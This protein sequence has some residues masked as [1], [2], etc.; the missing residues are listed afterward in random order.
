VTTVTFH[1][2]MWESAAEIWDAI[3]AHPFVR[4]LMDG[5]LTESQLRFYF[6]Q[7]IQYVDVMRRCRWIAAGKA[8]DEEALE[9]LTTSPE[10]SEEGLPRQARL[11]RGFGGDP[12]NLPERA[13]GCRGYTQHMLLNAT[14]GSAVDFL[15]AAGSCPWTYDRIGYDLVDRVGPNPDPGSTPGTQARA[16]WTVRY[17]SDWHHERTDAMLRLIDQLAA[18]CTDSHRRRLI[19]N[20]R[21]GM[22]YEWLFWD[23]A[24]HERGWPV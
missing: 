11:L 7:N 8:E 13:V 14:A 23:D 12:D 16:E 10:L 21:T 9:F 3:H 15:T 22:R 2:V 6:G 5:T 20:F 19:D 18:R 24:Y 17:G 1:D 4:G